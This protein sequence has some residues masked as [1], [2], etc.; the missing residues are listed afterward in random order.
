V[1]TKRRP[2]QSATRSGIWSW[3]WL[4]HYRRQQELSRREPLNHD[5]LHIPG[6]YT[7]N[8]PGGDSNRANILLLE[9]ARV[10]RQE[11]FAAHFAHFNSYYLTAYLNA[12][13]GNIGTRG[14]IIYATKLTTP[15]RPLACSITLD[16]PPQPIG[17]AA[18]VWVAYRASWNEHR[19]W[20]CHIRHLVNDQAEVHRFLGAPLVPAPEV[21]ADFIARLTR[22]H[23]LNSLGPDHPA[24]R[25]HYTP[26][27]LADH[28]TRFTPACVWLG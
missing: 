14:I 1:S 4:G 15:P 12:V 19:G 3:R 24:A 9:S 2:S 22:I 7:D 26:D 21:V 18:P 20:C 28:L 25:Y 11:D 10:D 17:L 13:I 23:T 6:R 5:E 16:P 27:E 8:I